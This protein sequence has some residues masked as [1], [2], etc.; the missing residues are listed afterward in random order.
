MEDLQQFLSAIRTKQP[1]DIE[2]ELPVIEQSILEEEPD[3]PRLY[4]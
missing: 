2:E 3:D 1:Q 4:Q